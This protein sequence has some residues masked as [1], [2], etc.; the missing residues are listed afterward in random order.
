MARRIL[1][2]PQA[3]AALLRGMDRMTGLLRPTLGPT[4]RT[5]AIDR[6]VGSDPPEILDS[7]AI[8]ARRML[9]LP[10]P[11]ED[12]GAMLIRHLAWRVFDRA[13]DGAATAAVLTHA[14]V[15]AGV[16]Y[17]AAGGNPVL[18]RRGME[19]GLAAALA[20]LRA[21]ARPID[22]PTE[23][24]R[25]VAGSLRSA[26]LAD[27]LGEV[28][29]AVG[30]DGAILVEDAQGTTTVLEYIDG[31]RWN[32]GYLSAFLLRQDEGSTARLL[33]PRVLVTDCPL[34]RAEDLLPTLEACVGAG[35]RNLLIVAP[36][37]RDAA[38]GLL[39][40]NRERG[41]L[42]GAM[43]VKAPAFGAQRTRILE[44]IAVITGGRCV[45]MDRHE[46]LADVTIDDLGKARQAWATR[47]AFGILGGQ[48][49]KPGIRQRIAEARAELGTI[50]DDAYVADK[51]RERIGKLAGTAALIRVGAAS[52]S[53]QEDL[54]FRIE[55]AV[56]SARSALCD[57]VVPGGGAALL[58][59]IPAVAAVAA[60]GDEAVGI[61]ALVHALAE[62]LR[63]ILANAGLEAAPIVHEARRR[64]E[65]EDDARVYDVLRGAWV[66]AYGAVVDPLPVALAA[67]ESSVSA[68]A[69]ALTSEVLI[70][71]KDPPLST[72][73]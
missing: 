64:A 54:K 6:L 65:A 34:D 52:K 44:D 27:M 29:D 22:G 61:R 23:I 60:S 59:C 26:E 63:A 35:E 49:S 1:D 15:H 42:D 25:V 41:M 7:A 19:R 24:A 55:A 10:D 72:T 14:L 12:M 18:V 17:L 58:A 48:G 16:R 56:L 43:A 30:P 28:V 9:Q 31:V 50:A 33:N 67:L 38:V 53:E 46:R 37:I 21:Q 71:R 47:V 5:V 13:G 68:A 51:I 32:E 66:G 3:L 69:L 45:C 20:A 36:D 11:F 39:V 73:P 8:I 2:G 4:P 62:P 40:V 57:G 70:H